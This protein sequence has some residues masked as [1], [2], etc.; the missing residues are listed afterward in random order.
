MP[1]RFVNSFFW[2]VQNK[3]YRT[4]LLASYTGDGVKLRLADVGGAACA[5]APA[6]L[7]LC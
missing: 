7:T 1:L 2:P 4:R 6:G 3:K 5:L